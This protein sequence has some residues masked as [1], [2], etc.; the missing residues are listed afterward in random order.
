M[1]TVIAAHRITALYHKHQPLKFKNAARNPYAVKLVRRMIDASA[2]R[3][4][5]HWVK[6]SEN[7]NR[8]VLFE[9]STRVDQQRLADMENV[10]DAGARTIEQCINNN[11]GSNITLSA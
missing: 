6:K 5:G 8:A 9:N 11:H 4:Y 2:F 10:D 1:H 7:Q 3:I